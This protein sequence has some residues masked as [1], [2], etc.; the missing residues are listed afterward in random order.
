[1]RQANETG[2]SEAKR[3]DKTKRG[4]IGCWG[5]ARE[6]RVSAIKFRVGFEILVMG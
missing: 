5:K 6:H 3:L 1:M 4:R 2:R